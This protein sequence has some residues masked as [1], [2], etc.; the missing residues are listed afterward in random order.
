MNIL[1]QRLE[2]LATQLLEASDSGDV[3]QVDIVLAKIKEIQ[4]YESLLSNSHPAAKT[5]KTKAVSRDPKGRTQYDESE[6]EPSGKV[7]QFVMPYAKFDK[8][9][10]TPKQPVRFECLGKLPSRKNGSTQYLVAAR[11]LETVADLEAGKIYAFKSLR[12][13]QVI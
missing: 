8:Q 7:F 6:V 5:Q 2:T 10:P 4:T 3:K 11:S 9:N 12:D 1:T 13:M